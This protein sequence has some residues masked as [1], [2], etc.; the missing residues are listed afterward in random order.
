MTEYEE[1]VIKALEAIALA[2]CR[3]AGLTVQIEP[4]LTLK[5]AGEKPIPIVPPAAAPAQVPMM[6]TALGRIIPIP[7]QDGLLKDDLYQA[8]LR[9]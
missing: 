1:R 2:Q 9:Q 5:I 8:A 4:S 3:L 6:V 7:L